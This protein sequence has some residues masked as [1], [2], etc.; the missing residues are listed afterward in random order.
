MVLQDS[1]EPRFVKL[2]YPAR[3]I[4]KFVTSGSGDQE[5][6][7]GLGDFSRVLE[8]DGVNDD[9]WRLWVRTLFCLFC[10][11][12]FP[13]FIGHAWVGQAALKPSRQLSAERDAKKAALIAARRTG[14]NAVRSS[15]ILEY[16]P[17]AYGRQRCESS[18]EAFGLGRQAR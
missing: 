3:V 18:R 8:V 10:R 13:D 12:R 7:N 1:A 6:L 9:F 17:C 16:R 5:L 11:F 4:L 14:G 15:M 2:T